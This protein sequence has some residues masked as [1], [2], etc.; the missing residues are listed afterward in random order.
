MDE[1]GGLRG[2]AE[3]A[4]EAGDVDVERLRRAEPVGVP[5]LVDEPLARDDAAG[6][7]HEEGEELELLAG[8]VELVAGHARGAPARV[9][10]H[11]PDFDRAAVGRGARGRGCGR[12]PTIARPP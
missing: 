5:D 10:P 11:G 12:L 6:L 1:A 8:E 4:A 3:L 2:V 7:A 9:E